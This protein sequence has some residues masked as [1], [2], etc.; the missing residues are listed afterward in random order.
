MGIF[1][2]KVDANIAY[3]QPQQAVASPLGGIAQ[4]VGGG[5]AQARQASGGPTAGERKDALELAQ[6][7]GLQNSLLKAEALRREG[8]VD[9]ANRAEQ[10][11]LAN[12]AR[13][14]MDLSS[15]SVKALYRATTGRD[16]EFMG[17]SQE[18]RMAE[19]AM[20]PRGLY[21]H[22]RLWQGNV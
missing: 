9:E 17:V 11:V 22:I 8:R 12:A 2:P 10:T 1:D 13:D 16:P 4:W 7:Q 15:G 19:A 6:T 14:G 18:E 21:C 5:I 20:P 3:E